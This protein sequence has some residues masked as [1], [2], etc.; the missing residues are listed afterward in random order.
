MR[1]R[2]FPVF[3]A[4]LL[5][6]AVAAAVAFAAKPKYQPPVDYQAGENA[7]PVAVADLN[8]DGRLDVA[9][10]NEV[11][12]DVSILLGK[13]KR[14]KFDYEGDYPGGD[15]PFGIVTG[16]FTGDRSIDLAV[17][18]Y[19]GSSVALLEGNGD[20]SFDPPDLLPVSGAPTSIAVGDLDGDR[21]SDLAIAG[22]TGL[23]FSV[24]AG[25]KNGF[26]PYEE[27]AVG[28]TEIT[29][30]AIAQ[31]DG[32]GP[33]DV[34]TLD[35]DQGIAVSRS[36]EGGGF[37]AAK[38]TP[39]P[40]LE[41]AHGILAGR[42]DRKP[43]T[44]IFV[45]RCVADGENVLLRATGAKS[46]EFKKPRYYVGGDC[47]YQPELADVDGNGYR[48]VVLSSEDGGNASV[49]YNGRKG[50]GE[51]V[52]YPAVSEAYSV[53]TGDFNRDGV[54]DFAV[55]DF[56]DEVTAVVLSK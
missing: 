54:R 25:K 44:D 50:L 23:T 9:T 13:G 46:V 56:G 33:R 40:D 4:V 47:T 7:Y 21:F 27:H 14:G 26:K 39:I 22:G 12:D 41:S 48:D 15:Y 55:P 1:S 51:A 11:D 32:K 18:D 24:L 37:R 6:A 16:D 29:S 28:S 49:L 2:T 20:G 35:F 43:G 52:D 45:A 34:V 8:G 3:A 42:I 38:E 30:I 5:A 10:G 36:R 19:E 17:A 31:L 53:A